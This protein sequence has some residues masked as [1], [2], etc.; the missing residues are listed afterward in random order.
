TPELDGIYVGP[1]DLGLALGREARL[2]QTDPIVV[3]QIERILS[4]AKKNGVPA[5]IH[6]AAPAYAA[7][8]IDLGYQ[9]VSIGSEMGLMMQAAT[10]AAKT[11]RD[12]VTGGKVEQ[13]G[14]G[15]RPAY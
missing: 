10:Q 3:E 15:D 6:C 12:G 2:D 7:K 14:A 5:G 8:M 1:S 9:L 11:V 13:T 4:V